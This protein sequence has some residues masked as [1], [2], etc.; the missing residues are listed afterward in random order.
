MAALVPTVAFSSLIETL[1]VSFFTDNEGI[2]S[3]DLYAICISYIYMWVNNN[4]CFKC[5]TYCTMQLQF[6]LDIP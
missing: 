4:L 1:W 2:Y 6:I 5:P 3:V